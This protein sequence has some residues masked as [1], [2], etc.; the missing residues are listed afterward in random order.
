MSYVFMMAAGSCC[1]GGGGGE[2]LFFPAH[3]LWKT[4][5]DLTGSALLRQVIYRALPPWRKV[6]PYGPAAQ[7]RLMITNLRV[8]LLR[9][10]PCPCQ[11]KD[12]EAA[13][14]PTNH[15]A[16]YDFIVKGSCLCNG[17]ADQCVPSPG[18]RA[19]QQ[20][21]ANMV[22]FFVYVLSSTVQGLQMHADAVVKTCIILSPHCL[23]NV[24]RWGAKVSRC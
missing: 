20:R 15:Y 11:A 17:H 13:A 5:T 16:V 12:L 7:H 10:Q 3:W 23:L 19:S 1:G 8:R 6:D 2:M 9:R 4:L 21:A 14:L 24:L 22:C 18:I